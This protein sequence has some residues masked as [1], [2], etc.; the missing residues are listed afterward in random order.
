MLRALLSYLE[1]AS[2]SAQYSCSFSIDSVSVSRPIEISAQDRWSFLVPH[3]AGKKPASPLVSG[4]ATFDR[5]R[6]AILLHSKLYQ[7]A[8]D[9]AAMFDGEKML[10][11]RNSDHA[12]V[13]DRPNSLLMPTLPWLLFDPSGMPGAASLRTA[14]LRNTVAFAWSKERGDEA[15]EIAFPLGATSNQDDLRRTTAWMEVRRHER[16]RCWLPSVVEERDAR[17]RT[18]RRT[19]ILEFGYFGGTLMPTAFQVDRPMN[20]VD[21]EPPRVAYRGS[22]VYGTS[23]PLPLSILQR[24]DTVPEIRTSTRTLYPRHGVDADIER[25]A[26]G[27]RTSSTS[28]SEG[29]GARPDQVQ[30][31]AAAIASWPSITDYMKELT[32]LSL[33]RQQVSSEFCLHAAIALWSRLEGG[34]LKFEDLVARHPKG[35]LS[36]ADGVK[37]LQA[38]GIPCVAAEV[39][40][41]KLLRCKHPVI[42]LEQRSDRVMHAI[43]VFLEGDQRVAW[44]LGRGIGGPAKQFEQKGEDV[45]PAIIAVEDWQTIR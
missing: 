33:T 11:F 25:I 18:A 22:I 39:Q 12:T 30:P 38:A 37:V 2:E 5:G 34:S 19:T 20:Y 36:V 1:G 6:F 16:H 3:L 35:L 40:R 44:A 13:W 21:D 27:G 32:V 31:A 17:G 10:E 4:Q 29:V 9:I 42:V 23:A 15:F 41:K 28:D 43:V 14:C 8:I 7:E 24:L 45:V 26:A